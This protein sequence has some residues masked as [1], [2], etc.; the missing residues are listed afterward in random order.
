MP[1]LN[2]KRT[3]RESLG[4]IVSQDYPKENIEILVVDGGS[5]DG[6]Q[7]IALGFGARV[8]DA[9]YR[10][11]MEPRR[12]VGLFQAKNQLIAYIDSDNILPNNQ[13]LKQMTQ[14]FI[15]NI[16]VFAAQTWRF[17]LKEGFGVF[18]RYCALI[19]ANDPVAF[20][21]G[22]SEKASWLS[23]RW[24]VSPILEDHNS[25]FLTR[26]D[27]SNL[28]TV[29]TNGFMAR[30]ELLFKAN[31]N[32][33]NFFHID[34]IADLIDQGYDLMAMVRNEIYHDTAAQLSNLAYKRMSYFL[35][36]NPFQSNRRYL[37]FNSRHKRDVL[38]VLR[39]A[40]LTVTLVEPLSLSI[41]GYL[42][43]RDPAWFLHPLVCW[44]FLMAYTMA[45]MVLYFRVVRYKL[46]TKV[47]S[48]RIF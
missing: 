20:Y 27:E 6:T 9:G 28:P 44:S 2:S 10:D 21:L 14:P 25:Y 15:D 30:R 42:R 12:S 45:S 38:G 4:S 5:N 22:K 24:D 34:V 43:K 23:D 26:F 39:F 17:G 31:S 29:G 46:S 11:N 40:I 36:H 47:F 18:N 13:Y 1:T 3:I 37:V 8:I 19:G 32:P 7:E 33:E 16:E 41:R 48:G 35:K